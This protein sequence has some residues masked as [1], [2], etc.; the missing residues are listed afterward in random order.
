LL[1][2]HALLIYCGLYALAI[3]VP[4][5]GIISIVARA[6]G[7]GFRST[8]P[9]VVGTAIGDWV[10]MTLSAFGLAVVARE[11]GSLFLVVKLAGALYLI[12]LGYKYWTAPV[13]E[14]PVAAETSA[15][16]GFF[17]QLA[18]TLGNP[19]AIVF[20]AALLPTVVDLDRLTA[21]GYAELSAATF[22][23]IPAITLAYAALASRVRFMLA[24]AA[25]RSR[26]NKSAAVIMIGAGLG[27]AVSS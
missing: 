27:V 4:G 5:P 26:V 23:L 18:L 19:K 22:V 24:S 3:A 6:L 9:A 15:S 12:Y 7:H 10:L 2:P 14:T 20:F 11:M 25:A 17:A 8:I 13:S 1:S 21:V 16:R